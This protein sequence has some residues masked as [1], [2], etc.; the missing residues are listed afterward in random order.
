MSQSTAPANLGF[1][2]AVRNAGDQWAFSKA[3]HPRH[4]LCN[5]A[6]NPDGLSLVH[7]RLATKH[8]ASRR[9]FQ[10]HWFA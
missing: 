2:T 4:R 10:I 1:V 5:L 6:A 8:A 9:W 3:L 7:M